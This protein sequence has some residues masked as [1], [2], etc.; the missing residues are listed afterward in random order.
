MPGT[1]T[2]RR[3][4]VLGTLALVLTVA[5]FDIAPLPGTSGPGAAAA[6]TTEQLRAAATVRHDGRHT[7]L[8]ARAVRLGA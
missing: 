2:F 6:A 1:H 7:D 4:V 8:R 5:K 3:S